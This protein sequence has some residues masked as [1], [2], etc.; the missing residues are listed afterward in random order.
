MVSGKKQAKI[1]PKCG[2]V[3]SKKSIAKIEKSQGKKAQKDPQRIHKKSKKKSFCFQKIKV[4]SVCVSLPVGS[5]ED[6]TKLLSTCVMNSNSEHMTEGFFGW[7]VLPGR[8]VQCPPEGVVGGQLP[9][10][11]RWGSNPSHQHG[12]GELDPHPWG[13]RDFGAALHLRSQ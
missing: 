7:N 1:G 5:I 13:F 12:T 3:L 6:G 10:P 11:G 8:S 4:K 2:V 9:A